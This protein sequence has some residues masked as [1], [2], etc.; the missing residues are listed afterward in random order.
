[1]GEK[2]SGEIGDRLSMNKLARILALVA[3]VPLAAQAGWV[4]ETGKPV[5]DTENM[6]SIA[7]FGVHLVLTPDEKRFIQTWNTSKT[8]PQLFTTDSVHRGS[9]ITAML[10]FHGCAV[11]SIG[12]CDVVAEFALVGPDGSRIPGG[13]GTVWSSEPLPGGRLQLGNASMNVGFDHDDQ[14][15]NYKVIAIVKDRVSGHTLS[16][17]TMLKVKE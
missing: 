5:P 3:Y 7:D 8:P 11:N 14:V 17:T 2:R 4:D 6:R 15:G 16:L 9:A 13:S 1:M 10:I 12:K